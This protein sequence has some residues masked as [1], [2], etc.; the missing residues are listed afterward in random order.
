[1][2]RGEA[3]QSAETLSGSVVAVGS[4]VVYFQSCVFTLEEDGKERKGVGGI[5]NRAYGNGYPS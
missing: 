5:E 1:M 4:S 2:G 3:E